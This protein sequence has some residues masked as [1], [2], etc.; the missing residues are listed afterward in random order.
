MP[1]C[2]SSGIKTASAV[3]NAG[4]TKLISIHGACT[5]IA[6]TT[7]KVFDNASA[8]SGTELARMILAPEASLEFDMHGVLALNGLY[9]DIGTGGGQGAAVSVEFA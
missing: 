8:A 5:G 4:R 6:P 9:L 2:R 7:I 1:T 3:I